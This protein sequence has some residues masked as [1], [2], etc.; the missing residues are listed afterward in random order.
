MNKL[1]NVIKSIIK[2]EFSKLKI[3][4]I[5]K[6]SEK[7][8]FEDLG[9]GLIYKKYDEDNY[10]VF[11]EYDVYVEEKET[12]KNYYWDGE[13]LRYGEEI[14][15]LNPENFPERINEDILI[16]SRLE[17][18]ITITHALNGY[19][20][21][22]KYFDEIKLYL[23]GEIDKDL[24]EIYEESGEN[25]VYDEY[26]EYV[27]LP[28]ISN[29]INKILNEIK[30]QFKK[31]DDLL[32]ISIHEAK[33]TS[34]IYIKIYDKEQ[35][36]EYDDIKV[37]ISDHAPNLGSD[38]DFFIPVKSSFKNRGFED[39]MSSEHELFDVF[40]AIEALYDEIQDNN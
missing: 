21:N 38:Y 11:N 3:E 6:E 16:Q 32:D 28:S 13:K 24:E 10:G 29:E 35:R 7:S 40:Q 22:K 37:R 39:T 31:Y 4:S 23:E 1:R 14:G 25:R 30:L 20:V 27:E 15:E 34:S 18:K 2:K 9:N 12:D 26:V 33:T 17:G 19:E 36:Y 5:L 8:D